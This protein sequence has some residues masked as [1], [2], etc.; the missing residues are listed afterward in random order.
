MS[1]SSTQKLIEINEKIKNLKAVKCRITHE[2]V[3]IDEKTNLP[4]S[5]FIGEK[6]F[7]RIGFCQEEIRNERI[8]CSHTMAT[9]LLHDALNLLGENEAEVVKLRSNL[10]D[11]IFQI[12]QL[13]HQKSDAE[14]DL[15]ILIEEREN[16]LI[17]NSDSRIDLA[18]EKIE[19]IES[20]HDKFVDKIATLKDKIVVELE[21]VIK[22]L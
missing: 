16:K 1:N 7:E 9:E 8:S 2:K 22:K 14:K 3:P 15:A 4:I 19:D 20:K 12:H 13:D 21:Y 18:K 17:G 10:M 6:V 5:K 11:V